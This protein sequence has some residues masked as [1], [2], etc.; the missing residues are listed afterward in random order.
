MVAGRKRCFGSDSSAERRKLVP[1]DRMSSIVSRSGS[2]DRATTKRSTT[3]PDDTLSA[4]ASSGN[5][6][7]GLSRT[8]TASTTG[9]RG[10]IADMI[11]R[12]P[13]S[14][15]EPSLTSTRMESSPFGGEKTDASIMSLAIASAAAESNPG[16]N[17]QRTV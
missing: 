2:P 12:A 4:L 3:S 11:R 17:D 6:G 14:E 13:A 8:G 1:E 5:D 10:K 7:D 9:M 16:I 15:S